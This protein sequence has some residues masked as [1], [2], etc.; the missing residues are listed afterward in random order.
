VSTVSVLVLIRVKLDGPS[1]LEVA[2]EFNLKVGR[3]VGLWRYIDKIG[4]NTII[5]F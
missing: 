4:Y 5:F 2:L 1:H 3:D